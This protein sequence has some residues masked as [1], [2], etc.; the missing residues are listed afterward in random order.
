[1]AKGAL[2]ISFSG[3]KTSPQLMTNQLTPKPNYL[4]RASARRSEVAIAELDTIADL[5]HQFNT[6]AKAIEANTIS[7]AN[8]ARA[9]GIHLQ[10]LCGHEQITLHFWNSHCEGKLPFKFDAAKIFVSTAHKMPNEAKTLAE[11]SQFIQ[12][13]LI[14]DG[15]LQLSERGH[16]QVASAIPLVQ[17]FFNEFQLMRQ[18]FKKI[19]QDRPMEEWEASALELFLSE[20]EWVAEERERATTLRKRK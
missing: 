4:D 10:T 18:P 14:A 7:A 3:S 17:K 1:M 15:L 16:T 12:T 8:L 13:L 5:F 11:A 9:M 2:S 6:D 19:I 20:T